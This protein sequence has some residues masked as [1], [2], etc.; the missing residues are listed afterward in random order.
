LLVDFNRRHLL[1][2]SDEPVADFQT[3]N[4][5]Q[6]KRCLGQEFDAVVFDGRLAFHPD[7][8]GQ[9]VGT[10]NAGGVFI[11]WLAVEDVRPYSQ[12][13]RR[14]VAQFSGQYSDFHCV[15]QNQILPELTAPDRA[16]YASDYQTSDQEQAIKA[17]LKVVEGHR[18]RP[19]VLSADRGRGKSAVLGIAAAQLLMGSQRK[20]I[21]TAP[22]LSAAEAVFRHAALSL[23]ATEHSAGLIQ[24]EGAELRFVA[25]DTLLAGD[26][27]ADL[28]L[29]DEAAVIPSPMLA[30]LLHQYSRIVFATTLHG[31][32]GTGRGFA[33][34]FQS[35]LDVQAPGWRDCHMLEPVRWR[36]DDALEAFSFDAL[37]LDAEPVEDRLVLGV[38]LAQCSIELVDKKALLGN[39]V[40]L[41]QLFGL[42]V[43][44]HYRTKPSDLQL[45]L[46]SEDI[47]LYIVRYN[48]HIVASVW[49][50]D[51]GALA[52]ALSE[53]IYRGERRLKGHLL[54]QSLLAHMGIPLAGSLRYQRVLRIAVHPV[55]Q[56]RG[57]AKALMTKVLNIAKG[58]EVDMV[59]TSFAADLDVMSFWQDS[60]FSIIRL[61][62]Q[63]DEV[64]GQYAVTLLH[65]C[66]IDGALLL[67]TAKRQFRQQW[68]DLLT[69][70]FNQLDIDTVLA[71]SAQC[72]REPSG[73]SESDKQ[74]IMR[75]AYANATYESCQVA[76]RTSV[77]SALNSDAFFRLSLEHQQLLV[78]RVLQLNSIVEVVRALGFS[79]KAEFIAALRL[80]S[81]CLL[82]AF[83]AEDNLI[84]ASE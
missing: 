17:I 35:L 15:N 77:S 84:V 13:F 21:V 19:L 33:V 75:F 48:E 25:P 44:A 56:R 69:M 59:G 50:V 18:R 74:E 32:E 55:L 80:A 14:V 11:L 26:Y 61:G 81:A 58:D 76:I 30:K 29:V 12:R 68:P 82:E 3:T 41:K 54:P 53:A 28:L 70:Q 1:F 4:I 8:F 43:L 31:Y 83:A 72:D 46:N 10:L 63:R 40:H 34:R 27:K 36:S 60:G 24:F 2:L 79:G 37:L 49:L 23:K 16:Q 51:E 65:S 20:I 47:T 73:L 39:E 57:F 7:S 22:S 42:M 78:V 71:I 64:S 5:K 62:T 66:S 38:E 9:S 67:D 6:A 52:P 45:L